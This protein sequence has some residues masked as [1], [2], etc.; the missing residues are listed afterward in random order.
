MIGTSD[1]GRGCVG[2]GSGAEDSAGLVGESGIGSG[3][4]GSGSEELGLSGRERG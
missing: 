4:T 1:D 2:D 3:S